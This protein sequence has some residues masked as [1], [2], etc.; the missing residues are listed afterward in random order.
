MFDKLIRSYLKRKGRIQEK[1][2]GSSEVSESIKELRELADQLNEKDKE[3]K[4]NTEMTNA[5]NEI[6]RS[7]SSGETT[8][9]IFNKIVENIEYFLPNSYGSIL[10]NKD[11]VLWDRCSPNVSKDYINMLSNGFPIGSDHGTCGTAAYHKKPVKIEDISVDPRWTKFPEVLKVALESGIKSCYSM[12]I[13]DSNDQVLGTIA[14]YS[15]EEVDHELGY[16]ILC[17]STKVA[18][19]VLDRDKTL[20]QLQHKKDQLENIMESQIDLVVYMDNKGH[21]TYANNSYLLTFGI[22]EEDIKKGFDFKQLIHPDD[23]EDGQYHWEKIEEPPHRTRHIQRAY[24]VDGLRWFEWEACLLFDPDGNKIG[25][26]G[27]GRD[28]TKRIVAEEESKQNRQLL[29]DTFNSI[30]DGISVLDIY[31]NIVEVNHTIE[32]W[33]GPKENMIGE[34]CYKVFQ[35]RSTPCYDCPT[36]KTIEDGEPYSVTVQVIDQYDQERVHEVNTYPLKKEDKVVGVIEYV[37]DITEK[38]LLKD[39]LAEK[40]NYLESIL[41]LQNFCVLRTNTNFEII[42]ANEAEI[43]TFFGDKDYLDVNIINHQIHPDS[44]DHFNEKIEEL[45]KEGYVH[46]INIKV[47]DKNDEVRWY[48]YFMTAIMKNN[49]VCEI[50]IVKYDVTE[51]VIANEKINQLIADNDALLNNVDF[52]VW[53]MTDEE[54]QG[55]V[56]K[57]FL[58]FFG[59][60]S[61]DDIKGKS[62]YELMPKDEADFCVR[63]NKEAFAK[64]ESRKTKE[65]VTNYNDEQRLLLIRK[66]PVISENERYI[67]CSAIDITEKEEVEKALALSEEKYKLLVNQSQTIIHSFDL[68]GNITY[69]SPSIY[70]LTGFQPDEVIGK[71][72][73]KFIHQEDVTGFYQ[74]LEQSSESSYARGFEFRTYHKNGALRWHKMVL[75]PLTHNETDAF[76]GNTIDVTV[77]KQ[78]E[79]KLGKAFSENLRKTQ[80]LEAVLDSTGG[81]LWYKDCNNRYLFCDNKFATMFHQ[82]KRSSYVYG[83]NDVELITECRETG[84]RHDFGELCVGTDIHSEKMQVQSR[85]IEGGIIDKKLVVLEVIKTPL[86]DKDDNYAGNVGFAWERSLEIELLQKDLEILRKQGRLEVLSK[87]EYPHSPFVYYIKPNKQ[88][89]KTYIYRPLLGDEEIIERRVVQR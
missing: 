54:T 60:K 21:I 36:L 85:Y 33:H 31:Q 87:K 51:E 59:Y 11:G 29:E 64:N 37:R 17:W 2:E 1:P 26:C 62:L 13:I 68:Q 52:L 14:I 4:R 19:L 30:L 75:T 67:V 80:I 9:N 12:P 41:N 71:N 79:Q 81:F 63:T 40:S 50:Q 83:K 45:F 46:D 27:S 15:T 88:H 34:K 61:S 10:I 56:N 53:Y 28:V 69:V 74:Y 24:T 6:L 39:E 89:Q 76:V 73:Q 38:E 25:M 8:E 58:K 7:L 22:T 72:I 55:S 86:F 66:N 5:E 78:A 3:I 70:N 47:I 43:H 57:T 35:K 82:V 32:R 49:I 77:R 23:L 84:L 18:T 44:Y 20:E 16:R 48:R 42:Y 65:W